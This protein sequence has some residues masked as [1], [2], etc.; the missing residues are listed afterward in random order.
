MGRI[1]RVARAVRAVLVYLWVLPVSLTGLL[2]A[3]LAVMS[4]G[5]LSWHTGVLEA[6]G[7]W[8]GRRLARGMPFS[9]PV[10]AITLGHVVVGV[11]A[12][13]LLGTRRHERAHVAQYAV[14]GVFFIL[15]YPLAGLW[16]GLRGGDVYRDNRFERQARAAERLNIRAGG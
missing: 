15:A 1:L 14:W 9:G 10:A 2:F 11:D 7:G 8:P 12:Q 16:A 3:L 6:C 4:G 5:R 13:A